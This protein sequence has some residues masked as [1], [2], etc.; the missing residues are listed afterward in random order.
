M[1][2]SRLE[3]WFAQSIKEK[4]LKQSDSLGSLAKLTIVILSYGRQDFLLRQVVYWKGTAVKL[5]IADGSPQA[6]SDNVLEV[7]STQPNLKYLHMPDTHSARARMAAKY[8]HTP[9]AIFLGDDEFHLKT[10]LSR[11][12]DK[13]EKDISFV[14]CIG[15]SLSFCPDGDGT[16]VTYGT[17]YDHRGYEVVQDG[18]KERLLFAM[19]NYNAASSYAV[20][21][22]PFLS[23]SW[24]LTS[25]WSS[26][27]AYELQHAIHTYIMGKLTSVDEVYWLRSYE[28]PPISIENVL[29]R[30]LSFSEWWSVPKFQPERESFVEI[31][32]NEIVNTGQIDHEQAKQII[33]EAMD[34]YLEFTATKAQAAA[35][36]KKNPRFIISK[37]LRTLLSEKQ[38]LGLKSMMGMKKVVGNLGSLNEDTAS[39]LA[40][41]E[42]LI[43]DFYRARLDKK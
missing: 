15:Q 20:Y 29:D 12:I 6:I 18:V 31:L 23:S 24:E 19:S 14:A 32:A 35:S 7:F 41:V 40:E 2:Q 16:T 39:E 27:Y 9:Y 42:T 30:K 11:A 38:V 26:P 36:I 37:L 28:N 4:V 5:V 21:R 22:E 10:G 8:I 25:E 34:S 13:L 17:G 33:L 43:S 1:Y 3:E